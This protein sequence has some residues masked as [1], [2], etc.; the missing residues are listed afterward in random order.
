M[1]LGD[2]RTRTLYLVLLVA[3]YVLAVDDHVDAAVDVA[4]AGVHA[5]AGPPVHAV[6]LRRPRAGADPRP[7][8]DRPSAAG[9]R[10]PRHRRPRAELLTGAVLRMSRDERDI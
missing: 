6:P 10:R 8:R 3:A 7:R 4:G 2:A 5:L 1:R 9:V